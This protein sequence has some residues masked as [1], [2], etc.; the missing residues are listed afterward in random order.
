MGTPFQQQVWQALLTIPYG[1]TI[2]YGEQARRIGNPKAV[3]V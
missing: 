2:S 1:E 3:Q